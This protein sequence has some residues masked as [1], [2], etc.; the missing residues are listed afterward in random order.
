MFQ[1]DQ[2]NAWR[3][4]VWTKEGVEEQR[5]SKLKGEAGT[6]RGMWPARLKDGQ[7]LMTMSRVPWR[8]ESQKPGRGLGDRDGRRD[9]WGQLLC[10]AV[11]L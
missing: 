1:Q 3:I 5:G 11:W 7:S 6:L 10:L 8:S 9:R 4:R 2:G